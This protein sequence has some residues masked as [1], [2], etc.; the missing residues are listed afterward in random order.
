MREGVRGHTHTHR[1]L[2]HI[3][4]CGGETVESSKENVQHVT[5]EENDVHY[6]NATRHR[7]DGISHTTR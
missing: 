3:N 1:G 6:N 5:I 2:S 4:I 7:T